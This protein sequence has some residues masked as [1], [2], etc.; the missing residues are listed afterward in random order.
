MCQQELQLPNLGSR[1]LTTI[2][3]FENNLKAIDHISMV[4]SGGTD[5]KL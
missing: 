1:R 5:E 3:L 4:R 2:N